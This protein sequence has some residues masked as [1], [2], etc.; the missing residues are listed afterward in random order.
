MGLLATVALVP[1]TAAAASI[2]GIHTGFFPTKSQAGTEMSSGEE[3]IVLSDP[4]IVPVV[5][6]ATKGVALPPGETWAPLL[7]RF[8]VP[9]VQGVPVTSQQDYITERVQSYATCKW[10]A[11][12]VLGD[13]A[14]KA[15][16]FAVI[17]TMPTW[18]EYTHSSDMVQPIHQLVT[19][20]QRGNDQPLLQDLKAN[21]TGI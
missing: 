15:Q 3:V 21:C 13:T 4:G 8:P 6:A 19:E 9:L 16:A 12:W 14:A 7:A 20:L 10:E 17:E 11:S 1:A 2:G 18:F 5:K